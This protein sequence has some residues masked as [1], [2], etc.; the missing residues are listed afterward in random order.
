MSMKHIL[1]E[2]NGR[3]YYYE[4]MRYRESTNAKW[5]SGCK[6][7]EVD[8]KDKAPC[9]HCNW[10]QDPAAWDASIEKADSF[11]KRR[12]PLRTEEERHRDIDYTK[13][14]ALADQKREMIKRYLARGKN[15]ETEAKDEND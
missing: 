13:K 1:T 8:P 9:S 12:H 7:Q 10:Y 3:I 11:C 4:C 6:L 2:V 15:E 14:K 5:P